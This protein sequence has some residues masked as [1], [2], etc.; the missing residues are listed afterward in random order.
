MVMKRG[1]ERRVME[2]GT[3]RKPKSKNLDMTSRRKK[4]TNSLAISK[5]RTKGKKKAK[6]EKE[7]ASGE[8][9]RCRLM[10]RKLLIAA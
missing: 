4:W 1:D 8:N 6:R 2:G 10:L 9:V 5:R 3:F 7:K